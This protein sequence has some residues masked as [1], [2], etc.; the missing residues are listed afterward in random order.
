MVVRGRGCLAFLFLIIFALGILTLCKLALVMGG[1]L[2]EII[3]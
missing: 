1:M 3:G 2:M